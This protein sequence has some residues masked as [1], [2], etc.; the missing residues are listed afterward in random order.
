VCQVRH[1]I[2]VGPRE[3]IGEL[4]SANVGVGQGRLDLVM[5]SIFTDLLE[6]K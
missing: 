4:A 3:G 1:A 2:D 5:N 6:S